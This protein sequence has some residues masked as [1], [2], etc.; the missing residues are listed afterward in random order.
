MEKRAAAEPTSQKE[1]DLTDALPV[2]SSNR[3]VDKSAN[4]QTSK[5]TN[6]IKPPAL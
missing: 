3:Q 1:E 6:T 5:T 4:R 2:K